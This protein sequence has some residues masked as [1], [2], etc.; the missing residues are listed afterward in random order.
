MSLPTRKIN[1][2][3]EV[4][5]DISWGF[6]ARARKRA[7]IQGARRKGDAGIFDN[8]S[9]SPNKRNAAGMPDCADTVEFPN[10]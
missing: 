6:V 1:P 4:S 10:A 2:D 9:R 5:P 3:T 7:W 8:M